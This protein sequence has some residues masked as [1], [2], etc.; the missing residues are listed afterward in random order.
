VNS[1]DPAC[2]R[3]ASRYTS[4]GP[5]PHLVRALHQRFGLPGFR[6][7]QR[8]LIEAV[9]A[10]RDALGILPT[11]GGKSLCYQLP[12]ALSSNCVVVIC[13]LLSLIQDQIDRART[14]GLRADRVTS[15]RS[16]GANRA[17]LERATCGALD[18]LF[19]APE[20]LNRPEVREALIAGRTSLFVVDEAH[21]IAQWGHDFRP[22]YLRIGERLAGRRAPMLAITAT[23]TPRVQH[24]IAERLGLESPLRWVGSFDRAN[25]HWGVRPARSRREKLDSVA[26]LVWSLESGAAIV[27]AG[28]R[29]AV[30]AVRGYLARLGLPAGAYHAGMSARARSRAQA[31][32]LEADRPILV[33]TNA[34]GMGIDRPDVRLV[35]HYDA[36]ASLEALY[37]EAGRGGRD[38]ELARVL[39]IAGPEPL[40][41]ARRFIDRARPSPRALRRAHRVL[42]TRAGAS[43]MSVGDCAHALDSD[44]DDTHATLR[45][46][47]GAGGVRLAP[48]GTSEPELV[49]ILTSPLRLG[50]A[51]LQRRIALAGLMAVKSYIQTKSCRRGPLLAHFG[52]CAPDSCGRCDRCAEAMGAS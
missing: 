26:T 38:G 45:A 33:A 19:M 31:R 13:P 2:P 12:A 1:H 51:R 46:L 14:L 23:A 29:R 40:Q 28:S 30:Q 52:E 50:S 37:Q 32:F 49:R 25:L 41:L 6:P 39:M 21:C 8:E 11:G 4:E 22:A 9:L 15:E 36:P 3:P 20:R 5:G 24:E 17:T 18:L 35:I 7:G 16:S 42:R 48:R 10:G 34:F 27:Y 44:L 43:P 47:S